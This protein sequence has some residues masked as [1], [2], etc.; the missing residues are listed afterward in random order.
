LVST[1]HKAN[2]ILSS[3][4]KEPPFRCAEEGWGEFDMKITMSAGK[5][6]EHVLEHDLNFAEERYESNHKVVCLVLWSHTPHNPAMTSED[7]GG[8]K[9]KTRVML[10][11]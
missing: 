11:Q 2:P 6:N 3:G 1:T 7:D 9:E 4:F 5:G 8:G 10:I